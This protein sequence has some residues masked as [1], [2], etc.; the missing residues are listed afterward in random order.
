MLHTNIRARQYVSV[1]NGFL[2]VAP[3]RRECPI[4][5]TSLSEAN[6][7]YVI[8]GQHISKALHLERTYQDITFTDAKRDPEYKEDYYNAV[9]ASQIMH[10]TT[11]LPV[12]KSVAAQHNAA[13]HAINKVSLVHVM[14]ALANEARGRFLKRES[15][16]FGKNQL[17]MAVI[18]TGVGLKEIRKGDPE[19]SEVKKVCTCPIYALTPSIVTVVAPI[20]RDDNPSLSSQI[21][22]ASQHYKVISFIMAANC[23]HQSFIAYITQQESKHTQKNPSALPLFRTSTF[24]EYGGGLT[25]PDVRLFRLK[26]MGRF[27]LDDDC[28]PLTTKAIQTLLIELK[29]F[30]LASYVI[31][32]P[33]SPV[34]PLKS[35][36][37]ALACSVSCRAD[38]ARLSFILPST[39]PETLAYVE[40]YAGTHGW[41]VR[42]LTAIWSLS[43]PVRMGVQWPK[44]EN[45]SKC[46]V[47]SLFGGA[48]LGPLKEAPMAPGLAGLQRQLSG[49]E[50]DGVSELPGEAMVCRTSLLTMGGGKKRLLWAPLD[51]LT[52]AFM[53]TGGNA[54]M[55]PD[56]MVVLLHPT[57][58]RYKR[59][60]C[61]MNED[62]NIVAIGQRA[63]VERYVA[64][65]RGMS[66]NPRLMNTLWESPDNFP[67][68][69]ASERV[70]NRMARVIPFF[71]KAFP[72]DV[73]G[74]DASA[75]D[76]HAAYPQRVPYTAQYAPDFAPTHTRG[77]GSQ[78]E[79][80]LG[81][82]PSSPKDA[83]LLT[84]LPNMINWDTPKWNWGFLGVFIIEAF[85]YD[86][87]KHPTDPL[88][89]VGGML[90]FVPTNPPREGTDMEGWETDWIGEFLAPLHVHTNWWTAFCH[91]LPTHHTRT[92]KSYQKMVASCAAACGRHLAE[93]NAPPDAEDFLGLIRHGERITESS[94]RRPPRTPEEI[95]KEKETRAAEKA[96]EKAAAIRQRVRGR[97]DMDPEGTKSP[98]EK[99]SPK[100]KSGRAKGPRPQVDPKSPTDPAAKNAKRQKTA[101]MALTQEVAASGKAMA[102]GADRT[103]LPFTESR[104][105]GQTQLPRAPTAPTS[106]PTSSRVTRSSVQDA[107]PQLPKEFLNPL[108]QETDAEGAAEEFFALPPS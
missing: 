17:A 47:V 41:T 53:N 65:M 66:P 31:Q 85:G 36:L 75:W 55:V 79:L 91:Q 25:L 90:L 69:G 33:D 67:K 82:L 14:Q 9:M 89:E 58:D 7:Y 43:V 45:I 76:Q 21:E 71:C 22:Y 102:V 15:P 68:V 64:V 106:T 48:A 98:T 62:R 61:T 63:D 35:M 70:K 104:A 27:P 12:L 16:W 50:A 23:E 78:V 92:P 18:R 74:L 5:L 8:G 77:L 46:D 108:T 51:M 32:H 1:A 4:C 28:N 97:L 99:R 13:Q 24:K 96:A 105:P 38:S 10:S 3:T 100:D 88:A 29:T 20:R 56:V 95:A 72:L 40:K 101:A 44:W 87:T 49:D 54:G 57:W 93:A 73:L 86:A 59:Q 11:T 26:L 2:S 42:D 103:A 60:L 84:Q 81:F 80:C 34:H 52:E 30:R 83:D 94:L 19:L 6:K 107:A 37:P 39:H